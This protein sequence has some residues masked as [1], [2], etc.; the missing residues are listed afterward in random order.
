MKEPTRWAN[1]PRR[2]Q[3]RSRQHRNR[4]FNKGYSVGC[5]NTSW[6]LRCISNSSNTSFS[7]DKV[8]LADC[9]DILKIHDRVAYML[10]PPEKFGWW[11]TSRQN[12]VWVWIAFPI[13]KMVQNNLI[14]M[15]LGRCDINIYGWQVQNEGRINHMGIPIA[16]SCWA[17]WTFS[18]NVPIKFWLAL[19]LTTPLCSGNRCSW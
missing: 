16:W 14:A 6:I 12:R 19:Y 9:S 3:H 18:V 10:G 11:Q 1:F 5:I 15:S 17:T 8:L 2:W 4:I 7:F 13:L